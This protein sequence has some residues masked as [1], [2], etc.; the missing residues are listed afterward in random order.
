MLGLFAGYCL[1]LISLDHFGT[2][3]GQII[4]CS[5]SVLPGRGRRM[6]IDIHM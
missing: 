3:S 4:Q 6:E 1:M 2:G 5:F